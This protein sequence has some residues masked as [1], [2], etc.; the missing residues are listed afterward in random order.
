MIKLNS[1]N[2]GLAI[3]GNKVMVIDFWSQYCDPCVGFLPV[4]TEMDKKFIR[5]RGVSFGKVDI[6]D[7]RSLAIE[8][9]VKSI[10]TI[11]VFKSGEKIFDESGAPSRKEFE[12]FI[13]KAINEVD[14][15]EL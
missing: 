10:P 1:G 2:I 11:M 9:G 13:E 4:Y 3:A 8:Y 6:D 7:N 12:E 15:S 5:T 14:K